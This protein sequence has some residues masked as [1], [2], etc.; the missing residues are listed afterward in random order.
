MYIIFKKL[1][2]CTNLLACV[3][4][5]SHSSIV[6][7]VINHFLWIQRSEKLSHT[8]TWWVSRA[9]YWWSVYQ[10]FWNG[11]LS[12]LIDKHP[13][14]KGLAT[15]DYLVPVTVL[16]A[17]YLDSQYTQLFFSLLLQH[18]DFADLLSLFGT[19]VVSYERS[20]F[21]RKIIMPASSMHRTFLQIHLLSPFIIARKRT[22]DDQSVILWLHKNE[23]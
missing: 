8:K 6:H 11:H 12:S 19:A 2:A 3:H 16:S 20:P 4:F 7:A 15:W 13:V 21:L 14:T 1:V 9:K 22:V 5:P 18:N 17:N 10:T 23:Q